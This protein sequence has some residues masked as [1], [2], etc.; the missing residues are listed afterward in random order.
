MQV[1]ITGSNGKIGRMLRVVW[2]GAAQLGFHP[3]WSTR[4]AVHDT[5]LQ[6]DIATNRAPPIAKGAVILHL[7]GQVHGDAMALRSNSSM[8]VKVCAAAKDAGASHVFLASS[9]AV[10][11]PTSDI[12][13]ETRA[14]APQ[15]DYGR[16]KLEME[17]DAL[18]WAQQA[19]P[20]APGV[21]CLRIGNV[22]GADALFGQLQGGKEVILDPAPGSTGGPLRSYIGPRFLGHVMTSLLQKVMLG[23][24]LPPILNIAARCP[25][26]MADL[27]L[28]GQLPYR[29]GPANQDVIPK[30][31][32]STRRLA[33]F[34]ALPKVDAG[35]LVADWRSVM[36]RAA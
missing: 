28:A 6:W 36:G 7:A 8:A 4:D 11:G 26:F 2:T 14:P 35:I 25:V 12:L 27:L 1:L 13:A 31:R 18:C 16:A 22:L 33:D 9:A 23:W 3:V 17:R 30:V 24:H 15:S 21:T 20:T 10:Y 19:G 5:D 32:L 34:V 29:F